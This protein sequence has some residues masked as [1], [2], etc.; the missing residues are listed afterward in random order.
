MC[1]D[2]GYVLL[3]HP[4]WGKINSTNQ[5]CMNHCFVVISQW[6][7]KA[8]LTHSLQPLLLNLTSKFSVIKNLENSYPWTETYSVR[9]KLG[10]MGTRPQ[11][12][13]SPTPTLE[14][15]YSVPFPAPVSH[16]AQR[17]LLL[18]LNHSSFFLTSGTKCS[19]VIFLCSILFF[20][21]LSF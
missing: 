9:T 7:E 17:V 12:V 1:F 6:Q 14:F 5:P 19:T 4:P 8:L 18:K 16:L 21:L 13:I 15:L 11:N 2:M 10:H 20:F 3:Y